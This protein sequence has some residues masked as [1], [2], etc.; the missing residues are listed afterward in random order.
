MEYSQ[1][2]TGTSANDNIDIPTLFPDL[3]NETWSINGKEGDDIIVG[4]S[5]NDRISGD[6]G[7]DIMSGGEGDDAFFVDN[8]GDRVIEN[9]G[10]GTDRVNTSV[11]NYVLEDHVEELNLRGNATTGYGN[12]L[13]NLLIGHFSTDDG[14]NLYGR[15]GNDR[16]AGYGGND[17]LYGEDGNDRLDGGDG[18]DVI[19]GG[20]GNDTLDGG[21]GYDQANYAGHYTEF[22]ATIL[23]DGRI[24]LQDTSTANG[25]EGTDILTGVEQI[26]F[27]R[28]GAYKVFNGTQENDKLVATS[29]YWSL[30]FGDAG[31]DTL[32][33][34]TGNDTLDGG[35]GYDQANYAGHYTEFKATILNDGR[36]QLQDTSTANGNEGTDILTGVE[37][38]NFARGGAYKVFNGTQENDK[39]VATSPYWSLMFGDAGNDTLTGGTGND[40]L[41]GGN[42][43]D[44]LTGNSGND[45]LIGGEGDDLLYGGDYDYS[46]SETNDVDTLFGGDGADTFFLGEIN[47]LRAGGYTSIGDFHRGEG[48]KIPS[49]W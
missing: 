27:A 35:T 18:N 26:N 14:D 21:T 12:D 42:G 33:G 37:Q 19:N 20:V 6:E 30:M 41:D 47:Y 46:G 8:V 24:Q 3:V 5:N 23:N 29:P 32:T 39:L 1:T 11:D 40:T 22:K 31:N 28:G 16:I 48:D 49:Y 44:I 43:D 13:D 34:G 25:N 7:A 4:G 2:Y 9:A 38:I 17:N 15:G 10:E 36:I 45:T